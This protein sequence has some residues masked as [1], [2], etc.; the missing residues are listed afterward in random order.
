MHSTQAIR[1]RA[2]RAL[3][4]I[5]T[6]A[7]GLGLAACGDKDKGAGDEPTP[8]D[9]EGTTG[10]PLVFSAIPGEKATKLK[11]KFTAFGEYLSEELGVPVTYRAADSYGASVNMF[12]KGEIQFA[13]FGG[14]TGVQARAKVDG[15]KAIAQGKADPKYY[16]YFVAHKDSGITK[17]DD[18]GTLPGNLVGK[19]FT[20]GSERSTSGR[21]MP[22]HFLTSMSGKTVE[23]L[24]GSKPGFSKAHDKTAKLV[25]NGDYD[26]GAMSYK[27][28]EKMIKDG[29]LDPAKAVLVWKT[30]PYADY[31]FSVRGDLDTTH[32]A[33]FTEKLQ[34]AILAFADKD[35]LENGFQ[36]EGFIPAKNEDFADVKALAQ[37]LG[38]LD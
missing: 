24:F 26:L 21:L 6:F 29:E 23:A 11:E 7:L 1:H 30:P 22:E 10:T 4:L 19:S 37:K 2:P 9:V 27:T 33:G 32:G 5:L 35:V 36:R 18:P 3:A 13:W 38:F 31:N 17:S 16:T 25:E 15:S 12:A 8:T 20:F 28:Y 34:K 14:L